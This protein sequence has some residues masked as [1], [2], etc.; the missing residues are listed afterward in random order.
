AVAPLEAAGAEIAAR[1]RRER[2]DRDRA[3]LVQQ[4]RARYNARV[5]ER[6]LPFEYEGSN[7]ENHPHRSTPASAASAPHGR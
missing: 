6:N 5:Y 7:G 1:L 2:A 4:A 3:A